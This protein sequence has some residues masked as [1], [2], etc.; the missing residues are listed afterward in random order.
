[1]T[2]DRYQTRPVEVCAMFCDGTDAGI[3]AL[4]TWFQSH[5]WPAS[6]ESED[7][8]PCSHYP[9]WAGPNI[10]ID[11]DRWWSVVEPLWWVIQPVMWGYEPQPHSVVMP[12]TDDVFRRVFASAGDAQ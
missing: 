3:E 4:V 1:M 7:P 8:D 11:N 6:Y 10:Q 5:G 9:E 2:A 12:Y